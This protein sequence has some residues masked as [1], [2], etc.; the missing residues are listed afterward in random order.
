MRETVAVPSTVHVP[1]HWT[2]HQPF[3]LPLQAGSKR[4]KELQKELQKL[5][6]PP[7]PTAVP[8]MD[9]AFDQVKQSSVTCCHELSAADAADTAD[10]ADSATLPATCMLQSCCKVSTS[11]SRPC[12]IRCITVTWPLRYRISTSPRHSQRAMR[13]R[14]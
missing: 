7:V 11:P 6:E 5:K 8:V 3:H 9:F 13:V 4:E 1:F 14:G 12:Y 10:T 2:F